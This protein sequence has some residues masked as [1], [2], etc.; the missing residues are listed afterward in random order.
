MQ[1]SLEAL[2]LADSSLP[3]GS[4][5]FSSGLECLAKTGHLQSIQDFEFHLENIIEFIQH[6][7][8][9]FINSFYREK[10]MIAAWREYHLHQRIPSLRDASLIQGRAWI[11]LS[12]TLYYDISE[13]LRKFIEIEQVKPYYLPTLCFILKCRQW[14]I[15]KVIDFYLYGSLRDQVS[16]AV[17]MG[18][19]MPAQSQKI[20]FNTLEKWKQFYAINLKL[21]FSDA[22]RSNPVLEVAQMAHTELYSKQFKT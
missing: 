12:Q 5:A 6:F 14:P 7:D 8:I 10:E 20:L 4:F 15:E 21:S 3:V 9:P 18:L 2:Q 1:L 13:K 11:R 17:R 19:L 22:H 16:A